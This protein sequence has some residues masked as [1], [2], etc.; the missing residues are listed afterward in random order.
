MEGL[1]IRIP[2]F[3]PCVERDCLQYASQPERRCI[4]CRL[5]LLARVRKE[6]AA[7]TLAGEAKFIHSSTF[8]GHTGG[9]C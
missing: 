3:F 2:Q 6:M 8:R 1:R 4:G 7:A 9:T 5:I